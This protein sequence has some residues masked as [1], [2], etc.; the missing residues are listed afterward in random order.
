MSANLSFNAF[1][2]KMEPHKCRV[3]CMVNGIGDSTQQMRL[4]RLKQSLNIC[5]ADFESFIIEA[6]DSGIIKFDPMLVENLRKNNPVAWEFLNGPI[7]GKQV[8]YYVLGFLEYFF[9][10]IIL[11]IRR[12][13]SQNDYKQK[14]NK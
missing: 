14:V 3:I 5:F 7:N 10:N 2:K 13:V 1:Q 9:L 4:F 8:L 12:R 11:F 6:R